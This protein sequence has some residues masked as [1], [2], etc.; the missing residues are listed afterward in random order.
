[1]TSIEN[2]VEAYAQILI[3]EGEIVDDGYSGGSFRDI[4]IEW[5]QNHCNEYPSGHVVHLA[6]QAPRE[7]F[8]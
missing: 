4:V 2:A 3:H 7:D 1:M 5:A 6:A 8:V